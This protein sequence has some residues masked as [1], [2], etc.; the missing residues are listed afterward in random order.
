MPILTNWIFLLKKSHVEKNTIGCICSL[1]NSSNKL[2]FILRWY[3]QYNCIHT[4][5]RILKIMFFTS[6]TWSFS[7][8]KQFF[9]PFQ[10]F[11]NRR[12]VLLVAFLIF[13]LCFIVNI[14]H[15]QVYQAL[16]PSQA[17]QTGKAFVLTDFGQ[18]KG[19]LVYT[20]GV[21]CIFLVL[22]PWIAIFTL[23]LLILRH[24]LISRRRA[25]L[26]KRKMKET[27][28]QLTRVL[29]AV[30]IS[31]LLLMVWQCVTQCF[32]MLQPDTVN[33]AC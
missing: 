24:V 25:K 16:S 9:S 33:I 12:R 22:V 10:D 27:Q 8:D 15:F 20:F 5:R 14:P 31:F 4:N 6:Y 32:H 13:C 26:D 17:T 21:H 28:M 30:T 11:C 3:W 2:C 29:L 18:G 1:I 23:N 19:A 7:K